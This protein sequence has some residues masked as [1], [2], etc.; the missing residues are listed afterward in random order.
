MRMRLVPEGY[1]P[2]QKIMYFL[3]ADGG[4]LMGYDYQ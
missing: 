2:M 3:W 1:F 4:F